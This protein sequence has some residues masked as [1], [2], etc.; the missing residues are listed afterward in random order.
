[1]GICIQWAWE[2]CPSR[3]QQQ[4]QQPYQKTQCWGSPP[5]SIWGLAWCTL[6]M[7]DPAWKQTASCFL[8]KLVFSLFSFLSQL[9]RITMVSSGPALR[10]EKAI[11]LCTVYCGVC[12]CVSWIRWFRGKGWSSPS[13]LSCCPPS[14]TISAH[15][16]HVR[17]RAIHSRRGCR[18]RLYFNAVRYPLQQ[19]IHK[20][21]FNFT[22]L[23]L[24]VT[25][26]YAYFRRH[27]SLF[28][29]SSHPLDP[30]FQPLW[31][32]PAPTEPTNT[33]CKELTEPWSAPLAPVSTRQGRL[34]MLVGSIPKPWGPQPC[35]GTSRP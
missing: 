31:D 6:F 20:H 27:N 33:L 7:H 28:T 8:D 11:R 30:L 2:L 13:I 5:R 12:A 14:R 16:I 34:L 1:M 3:L 4:E 35:P 32:S 9:T 19:K 17:A 18:I 24:G 26:A 10:M 23:T 21:V 29:L 22:L 15:L 25:S